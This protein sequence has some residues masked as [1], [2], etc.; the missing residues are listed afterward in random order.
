MQ[1]SYCKTENEEKEIHCTFCG[2]KLFSYRPTI[3]PYIDITDV[4]KTF[5]EISTYHTYDLL[6]MLQIARKERS[7]AFNLLRITLKASNEIEVPE[8]LKNNTEIEYRD[9][10]ARMHLIEE[11]LIDRIGYKPNRVDDKLLSAWAKRIGL[12]EVP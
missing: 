5:K 6:R 10:T 11:I 9:F 2:A 4:L 7:E 1:C 3:K 8:D 12:K